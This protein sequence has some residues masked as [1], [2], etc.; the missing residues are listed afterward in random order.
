MHIRRQPADG[1]LLLSHPAQADGRLFPHAVR[2]PAAVCG[3]G[4]LLSPAGGTRPGDLHPRAGNAPFQCGARAHHK[5][6]FLQG[7][8][9]KTLHLLDAGMR[10]VDAGGSRHGHSPGP[11]GDGR[12]GGAGGGVQRA[13]GRG[14]A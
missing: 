7:G 3:M 8:A 6:R 9:Q 2:E 12:V 10:R 4:S 11:C 13:D 5:L 1:L 14:G